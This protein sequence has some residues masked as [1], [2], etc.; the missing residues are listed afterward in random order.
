MPKII[1]NGTQIF[2]DKRRFSYLCESVSICVQLIF[3]AS[4]LPGLFTRLN[5]ALRPSLGGFNR[6]QPSGLFASQPSSLLAFKLYSLQ[7][8]K[9]FRAMNCELISHNTY[10]HISCGI[11]VI[12]Y[13]NYLR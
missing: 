13:Q 6:G 1:V 11:W 12:R 4:Q 10:H 9:L 2:A 8:F 5:A 3:L 7:A